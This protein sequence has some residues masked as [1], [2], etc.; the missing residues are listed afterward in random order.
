MPLPIARTS[1]RLSIATRLSMLGIL[2][3]GLIGFSRSKPDLTYASPSADTVLHP[4][5]VTE[6]MYNPS[7]GSEYEFIELKNT[8]ST[9]LDVGG[10]NF[11]TG[12]DFAFALGTRLAP[13][14][15]VVLVQ[16]PAAFATRYPGIPIAGAY[17]GRLENAGERIELQGPAGEPVIDVT[18]NDDP[19]WPNAPDGFGY[20]LV[21]A[22]IN[23]D[24]NL[25]ASWRASTFPNGSP[26]RDDPEP[27]Y[28]SIVINEVLSHSDPP[29][30]DAI[31]L[32]NPSNQV[33]PIGGWFLSDEASR[34]KKFRIPDGTAIQPHG[35]AAFYEY[36]FNPAPGVPP[37]FGLSAYGDDVFLSSANP[38]GNLT[39]Y[40]THVR[41]KTTDTNFPVGRFRTSTGVDFTTLFRPT[42]GI[43]NPSSV[44]QF[45]TGTGAANASAKFGPIVI[46]ELM[47]HPAATADEYV[48]LLNVSTTAVP[49]YDPL[50]TSNTWRVTEGI[51]YTFPINTVVP[52]GGYLLLVPIEP[53]VFRTRYG[54]PPGIPIFGPYQGNLN[55][56]GEPVEIAMPDEEDRGFVP[57][58]A[59]DTVVYDDEAPW[60]TQ[61]D[62]GGPSLERIHALA[63]SNEP[64]NWA[65]SRN[66]GTPG[67]RNSTTPV[68]TRGLYLPVVTR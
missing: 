22:A 5:R 16:D 61:P 19:P 24:P 18:Y 33:V 37:S 14:A 63:Y 9:S 26:G 31:E 34:L 57:Y 12:I 27:L 60:P 55:N 28:G 6:I 36:Q 29:F 58:F 42:F 50:F 32:Y 47:Y 7:G 20:S 38:D 13:G 4:L 52:A 15:L 56:A 68:M 2:L 62:E 48:E 49:L 64:S 30:E 59:V 45:R 3:L 40:T 10:M 35:Y 39:G 65:A 1:K 43:T 51:S 23:G 25:G 53:A 11:T 41:F 66:N 46:N 17:G 21:I 67:R 8:S 44:Q 54:I